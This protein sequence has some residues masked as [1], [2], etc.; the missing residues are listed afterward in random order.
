MKLPLLILS[1]FLTACAEPGDLV[2]LNGQPRDSAGEP[3]PWIVSTVRNVRP[4]QDSIVVT[5]AGGSLADPNECGVGLAPCYPTESIGRPIGGASFDGRERFSLALSTA[6][7]GPALL[8]AGRDDLVAGNRWETVLRPES[9]APLAWGNRGFEVGDIDGDGFEDVAIRASDEALSPWVIF[10]YGSELG[11]AP[12]SFDVLKPEVH[13]VL[14]AVGDRDE[15]GHDDV[16]GVDPFGRLTLYL[17]SSLRQSPTWIG[18]SSP[19]SGATEHSQCVGDF[20]RDGRVE[21]AVGEPSAASAAG[22][23]AVR[24]YDIGISEYA[25]SAT[26]SLLW[27]SGPVSE[28]QGS[29]EQFGS[30]VACGD[31]DDDGFD[32]LAVATDPTSGTPN[33]VHIWRGGPLGLVEGPPDQTLQPD[34]STSTPGLTARGLAIAD[35]EGDGSS[36]LFVAIAGPDPAAGQGGLYGFDGGL[37]PRTCS[38]VHAPSA[39]ALGLILIVGATMRRRGAPRLG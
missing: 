6:D 20:D 10:Y 24:V 26:I 17:G 30:D 39:G 4:M 25:L 21:V 32:D 13:P 38:T 37:R 2:N 31:L 28:A 33:A 14:L 3:D 9:D 19:T 5:L 11:F 16:V 23:G 12:Y 34:L 15:D 27:E 7:D 35:P 36:T 22:T 18:G 1:G 8:A 29:S